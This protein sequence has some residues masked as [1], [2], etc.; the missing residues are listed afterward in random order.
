M[1][2]PQNAVDKLGFTEIKE[3][4][5]EKC[6]SESARD[7]VDRIQPQR[8]REEIKR[9]LNQTEEYK[10]LIL[11]DAPLVIDHFYPLKPLAEKA[12]LEGAFLSE[13]DFFKI[14]RSLRTVFSI[15]Q[16][17][18]KREGRY[19]YLEILFEHLPIEKV[20]LREIEG[21][22]NKEGKIKED[23]S[24][25]L[26][27]IHKN[28]LKKEQEARKKMDALLREAQAK[29]YTADGG[30]TIRS[31]RLCIPVLAEHKR[32]IKGLI[33]DESSTGQTVY[34][35]PNAVFE[36]NNAIRDLQ[37]DK[38]REVHRI[39]QGL[40]DKIR[41]FIPLFHQ[42]HGLLTKVD[43]VR[44]KALFA[45]EIEGE[46]PEIIS[47][48][49]ISLEHARH[50][51]L[52]L[53]SLQGTHSEVVPLNLKIDEKDRIL[54]VSGPNA[55]GKSVC[56]KTVGLLQI[57]VQS[58]L[59]I[60]ADPTS[61]IGVFN[62]VFSDI[63]DD[64]SIE[65]DLSTYSAHLT[66]MKVF[67]N[68]ANEKSLVLIDEFGT[69]TDPKF[70]GP[71]AEAVLEILNRKKVKGVITTHYSNLKIF[72]DSTE[73]LIN[74][75]MLFDSKRLQPLYILQVGKPG[76]SYAFEIAQNIGLNKEVLEL[77]KKKIGEEQRRMESLLV[78]LEREKKTVH[79][80]KIAV[81]KQE[82]ELLEERK[83]TKELQE[84][85]DAN[86]RKLLRE[87]KE[88]ARQVL[89]NANKLIENTISEIKHTG[90]E[91]ESTKKL[92]KNIHNAI[93]SHREKKKPVPKRHTSVAGH[94]SEELKVG[95]WVKLVDTGTEGE[96][97]DIAKNENVIIALGD[98]RTVVK[99]SRLQKLRSKEKS[100]AKK[101]IRKSMT[102]LA[103]DFSSELD[104]RG[105]R[106]EE[107]LDT[108]ESSLDQAV[109][110]GYSSIKILHGKGNG[111]LRR[112]I[113]E[114]L[115]HYPHISH[116]EDEH[117]DR[118]GEGITYAYLK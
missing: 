63:G 46:M 102:A 106:T 100:K 16:Y 94:T 86:R 107:A 37:F 88:E 104:V 50:P 58:G 33:H 17:F 85:L 2:F 4:I 73:G 22:L 9:F 36:L 75:S 64:Q 38:K 117:A 109:M 74:A 15:I 41:P 25:E 114:Y 40:T 32:K 26:W 78:D 45:K 77:A 116:Y 24:P 103:T 96:V 10:N 20:I 13:E 99:K 101:N 92:R 59:L 98:L 12:R 72:A 34:L 95:D 39:L 52:L 89:K 115:D 112:F 84:Y 93:E 66:N 105:M 43:F 90:A 80:I 14:F 60:P 113:R 42:Y 70:G 54:L 65:S 111:I 82:R 29:N 79:D 87:A 3:Y 110:L 57:M 30:L 35:E 6:L 108:I 18:E 47:G 44:A 21:V 31:G 61:Q 56:L 53:Q 51:L 67:T 28:I 62:A 97:I 91:K 19:P 69:G 48:N 5:K 8:K 7:L 23:A 83:K 55:G 118:G 49:T 68:K 81:R 71:M 11:H 76:S 27:G 1:I